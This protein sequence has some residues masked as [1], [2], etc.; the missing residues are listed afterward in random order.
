MS[1]WEAKYKALSTAIDNNEYIKNAEKLV[2]SAIEISISSPYS[3][4][5]IFNSLLQAVQLQ[6]KKDIKNKLKNLNSS[7]YP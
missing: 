2:K 7:C 4:E 1:E 3:F 5:R 6:Q